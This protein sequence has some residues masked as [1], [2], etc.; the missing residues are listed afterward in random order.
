[1]VEARNQADAL[2]HSLEKT[3]ADNRDRISDHDRSRVEAAVSTLRDAAKGDD[4]NAIRRAMDDAQK[5]SHEMAESLYKQAQG[6]GSGSSDG[7]QRAS[8]HEVKEGEVV[9]G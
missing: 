1:M 3:I 9:E 6:S 2:A 4:V 7:D 5:A 8:E